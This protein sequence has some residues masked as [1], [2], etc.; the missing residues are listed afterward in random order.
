MLNELTFSLIFILLYIGFGILGKLK[1]IEVVIKLSDIV[2][3]V[4][5]FSISLWA[6]TS[7]SFSDISSIL[8][9]SILGSIIVIIVTYSLGFL[10]DQKKEEIKL[11]RKDIAS[12]QYRYGIPFV[13]GW[14]VGMGIR[15]ELSYGTLINIELLFLASFLGYSTS[16]SISIDVIRKSLS[17]GG[18]SLI[19]VVIGNLI[20]GVILYIIGLGN[21]KLDEIISMGSG[22]YTFTGP[23]VSTYYSPYYGSIAFL[24]NFFREQF[25]YILIPFLLKVKYSPYSAIAVGGA[26]SMDTTLPLYIGLLG[27][28]YV[29][30]AV[31]SGVTLT[32]VIPIILP[33]MLNLP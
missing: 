3:Y 21:L 19:L 9:Y 33:L 30:T 4:L 24:I 15:P 32:A 6:G 31:F 7:V 2:V 8:I 10:L 1:S 14:I 28:E 12:F 26:T 16:K 25:S 18:L 29:I 22:W 13:L 17:K 23:L 27:D 5:I 20:S 11:R